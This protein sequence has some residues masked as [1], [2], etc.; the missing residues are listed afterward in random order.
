[1]MLPAVWEGE[2]VPAVG[3]H[4]I[5]PLQQSIKGTIEATGVNTSERKTVPAEIPPWRSMEDIFKDLIDPLYENEADDTRRLYRA[6]LRS[7]DL[8]LFL[9]MPD[10]SM[11]VVNAVSC[12]NRLVPLSVVELKSS[13]RGLLE[14]FGQA[15]KG[16]TCVAAGLVQSEVA[17]RDVTVSFMV[18]NGHTILFGGVHLIAPLLPMPY[19]TYSPLLLLDYKQAFLGHR[20]MVVHN[21]NIQRLAV[22]ARLVTSHAS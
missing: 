18:C 10:S 11:D 15:T 12:G 9:F 20:H 16:A 2:D 21:E 14:G 1:M 8:P 4:G 22:A 6:T 3:L 5:I 17:W 13:S 7:L 19:V